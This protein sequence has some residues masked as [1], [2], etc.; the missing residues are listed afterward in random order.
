MII[1]TQPQAPTKYRPVIV[2]LSRTLELTIHS[3]E[4]ITI[5]DYKF[6]HESNFV[7]SISAAEA[8]ALKA[9]LNAYL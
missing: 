5:T 8:S 4:S 3:D 1:E 2:M 9:E 6:P 7:F